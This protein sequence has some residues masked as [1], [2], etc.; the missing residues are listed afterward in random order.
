V[1]TT[2]CPSVELELR[3][4]KR[5]NG[6]ETLRSANR[7]STRLQRTQRRVQLLWEWVAR[8]S[9]WSA[10]ECLPRRKHNV[11]SA[12]F[13]FHSPGG[14]TSSPGMW[15]TEDRRKHAG[16]CSISRK[17]N[18]AYHCSQKVITCNRHAERC[19]FSILLFCLSVCMFISS[20]G[21]FS[22]LLKK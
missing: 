5:V 4:W 11:M 10:I 14:K 13:H 20:T 2:S 21:G 12:C 22:L 8:A 19:V 16:I 18:I 3:G 6:M 9:V 7:I 1:K 15:W 17:N